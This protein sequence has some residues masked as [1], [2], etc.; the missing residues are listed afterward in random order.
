[1]IGNTQHAGRGGKTTEVDGPKAFGLHEPR[2]HYVMRAGG[3]EHAGL[4]QQL[5]EFRRSFH[6]LSSTVRNFIIFAH[7]FAL[8][9]A[10]RHAE[11]QRHDKLGFSQKPP[12]P[13]TLHEISACR[14]SALRVPDR[15]LWDRRKDERDA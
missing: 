2:A 4:A 10:S 15:P 8:A 5:P 6:A 11:V 7:F 3:D 1:M 12:Q 13:S 9:R 14:Y